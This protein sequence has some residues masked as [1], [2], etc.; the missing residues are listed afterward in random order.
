MA[1]NCNTMK[2]YQLQFI[3]KN[4]NGYAIVNAPSPNMAESVFKSQTVYKDA[5]VTLMTEIRWLGDEMQL[6]TEGSVTTY[7]QSLYELAVK[8]GFVGTVDD[9]IES[10]KIIEEGSYTEQDPIF[11]ASPAFGITEQNISDWN[12]K[13]E[14]ETEPDFHSSPASNI[15]QQDINNWNSY[16]GGNSGGGSQ[17]SSV[18]TIDMTDDL[19]TTVTFANIKNAYNQGNTIILKF[20]ENTYY[21]SFIKEETVTTTK[22]TADIKEAYFVRN[23]IDLSLDCIYFYQPHSSSINDWNRRTIYLQQSLIS[24]TS[25]KTINNECLLGSGNI[26][27]NMC[28]I[29]EDT[30][31]SAVAAITGVAPFASL[32]DGQRI[33]L[34]LKYAKGASTYTLEL[35]LNDGATTTGAKDIYF[36]RNGA[37]DRSSLTSIAADSYI[38]LVYDITNTRWV[39]IGQ[40]DTNTTYSTMT[41]AEISTGTS[42]DVRVVSPKILCDNFQKIRTV[43]SEEVTSNAVTITLDATKYHVP[44]DEVDTIT[45][46]LP[47]SYTAADEF[48]LCFTCHSS[49]CTVNLPTGVVLADNCDNFSEVAAG[50][51]FQVSIMHDVAA[52]LCVTP[53]TP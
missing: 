51:F 52:Y 27:T 37:L 18:F 22:G 15:T 14:Q 34:H 38:E 26:N 36:G 8:N 7:G 11:K 42:T 12:N 33:L 17:N 9:F 31:S 25:I 4:G 47:S 1:N 48:I 40:V 30:R 13:L 44:N 45:M 20:K 5:K 10:M 23:D 21:L 3:H 35:T 6:V 50:V 24:G 49:S 28:P 43:K 19:T 39:S 16:S 41:D 2:H 29:I 53:T 46:N 32:V